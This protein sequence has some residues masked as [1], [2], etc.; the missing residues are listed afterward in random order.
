MTS[1]AR[2]EAD[3]RVEPGGPTEPPER[4]RRTERVAIGIR[5]GLVVMLV[6]VVGAALA[7]AFG[8]HARTASASGSGYEVDV[9]YSSTARPGITVPFEVEVRHEGGFAGPV[10]LAI[11]ADYLDALQLGSLVPEPTGSSADGDRGLLTFEPSEGSDT[12][13]VDWQAEVD[14]A[15]NA[16]RHSGHV[17]VVQTGTAVATARFTTWVWP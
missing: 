11:S 13:D 12:L 17:A 5:R 15:T 1:T 3:R 6:V 10:Q 4:P 7:G 8:V 9:R 14:P 2:A 16:G